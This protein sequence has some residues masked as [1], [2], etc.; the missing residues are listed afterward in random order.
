MMGAPP[1]R[2]IT[3][4]DRVSE[5]RMKPSRIGPVAPRATHGMCVSMRLTPPLVPTAQPPASITSDPPNVLP[6]Q[7]WRTTEVTVCASGSYVVIR[8]CSAP[9][10]VPSAL[11][12]EQPVDALLSVSIAVLIWFVAA[13]AEYA[14]N[15]SIKGRRLRLKERLD[16]ETPPFVTTRSDMDR[17]SRIITDNKIGG[18]T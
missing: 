13:T 12:T 11:E 10:N 9:V 3:A 6:L 7:R 16:I 18:V 1:G 14:A 4:S 17:S 15:T 8:S 2:C 5:L